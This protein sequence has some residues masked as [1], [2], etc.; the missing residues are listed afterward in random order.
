MLTQISNMR[1]F[2]GHPTHVRVPS[3]PAGGVSNN[4]LAARAMGKWLFR[5]HIHL[6]Y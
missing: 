5:Y 2:L 6:F 1:P 3:L 4:L